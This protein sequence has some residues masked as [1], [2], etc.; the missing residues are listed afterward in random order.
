MTL[1]QKIKMLRTQKELTQK[2]LA[3][4]VH[5]TFQTVSKWEKDENEPDVSTL[6][7][8]ARLFGCSLDYLLSED[9]KSVTKQEVV[10]NPVV[11]SQEPVTKTI[12][13]H[14][15]EMH[16]CKRCLK[17]IPENDLA[18]DEVCVSEYHRGHPAEYRTDYYHRDCLALTKKERE[19]TKKRIAL[20]KGRRSK[21]LSFGWGIAGGVAALGLCLGLFLGLPQCQEAMTPVVS[22]ILSIVFSYMIFADLYCIISGSYVGDVFLAI[23][24]W[25]IKMPGV[26]F[27]WDI[28]GIVWAIAM[29]IFL[30]ILGFILGILV[31][32]F[33]VV[34]SA[35]LASVSFPF[36]LVHN[37]KTNYSDGF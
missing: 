20:A 33:A 22:V 28:E 11:H 3:D 13:I 15:K 9:E 24:G 29:K 26:I 7:E 35:V 6:R 21:K 18:L 17:D 12:I 5:V 1:G 2:D 36:V 25:S 34:L 31:I 30:A 27:S 37:I 19:E 10:E 23:G 4:Q 8:L 16:V 32:G 14:Q